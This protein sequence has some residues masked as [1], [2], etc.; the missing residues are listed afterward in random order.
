MYFLKEPQ[1]YVNLHPVNLS[2]SRSSFR[3][4][5]IHKDD[6]SNLNWLMQQMNSKIIFDKK[7]IILQGVNFYDAGVKIMFDPSSWWIIT[8]NILGYK[9]SKAGVH[10]PIL[11]IKKAILNN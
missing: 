1:V 10:S 2:K 5:D 6:Y 8:F 3:V 7:K 4:K 9:I 11:R